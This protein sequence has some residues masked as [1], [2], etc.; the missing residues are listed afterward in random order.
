MLEVI[1]LL[2]AAIAAAG[3]TPPFAKNYAGSLGRN[4]CAGAENAAN[5]SA[6]LA[7]LLRAAATPAFHDKKVSVKSGPDNCYGL[8]RLS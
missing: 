1:S 3:S 6:A 8:Q 2:L 7:R 5:E 4:P